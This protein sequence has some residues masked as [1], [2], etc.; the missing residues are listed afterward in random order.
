M[1]T[2]L[3]LSFLFVLLL[4]ACNKE[5]KASAAFADKFAGQWDIVRT[6]FPGKDSTAGDST[7]RWI[8]VKQDGKFTSEGS[9]GRVSN[10]W[11]YDPAKDVMCTRMDTATTRP[12]CWKVD[13]DSGKM[14][15][16]NVSGDRPGFVSIIF[17]ER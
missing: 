8:D 7:G 6:Y 1:R 12:D 15:W 13:V 14:R 11:S 4:T 16:T 5:E 17:S 10:V 2:A 3:G 9:G